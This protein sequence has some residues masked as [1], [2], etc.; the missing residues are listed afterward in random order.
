MK[1]LY[2][3]SNSMLEEAVLEALALLD[4]TATIGNINAKVIEILSLS[5]EIVQLED[6]S[7]LGTKLDY[8]LRWARTNLKS[9]GKIKNVTRGTWTLV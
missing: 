4:G 2:F 8:R 9:K 7:G 1:N 3:P 5:D 6:E